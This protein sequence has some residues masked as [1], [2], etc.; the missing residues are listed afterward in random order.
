MTQ[1]HLVLDFPLNG[2][3]NAKALTDELT[4]RETRRGSTV[5]LAPTYGG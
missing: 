3:A 1:D 5:P 2:R 4:V